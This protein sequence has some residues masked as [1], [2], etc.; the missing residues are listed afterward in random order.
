MKHKI[1]SILLLG[2]ILALIA[3]VPVTPVSALEMEYFPLAPGGSLIYNSTNDDGTWMTKRYIDDEW[4]FLGGPYGTFTILW[5]EAQM[6]PMDTEYTWVNYMWLSKTADTLL[7]WGFE[8]AN[9]KI[10]CSSPL[11]YVTEPV[12]VGAV[13]RGETAG[14]LT[15]KG[16]GTTIPNIAFAANY[17]IEAKETVTTPAGTFENCIKIHEEEITPDGQISFW[18]WYAPDV[19]AIQYYY[20]QNGDRWDVLVE[21]TVDP[22][23]DPWNSWFLPQ[24]PTVLLVTT[25]AVV[26]IIAVV[27]L[28]VIMKKRT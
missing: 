1:L 27:A 7:W 3:S 5:A 9:A 4:E 19:G 21:Y 16:D 15:L 14:T 8:D 24:V 13:H 28:R 6:M 2:A 17:T 25:I 22:E 10:V 12:V 11:S 23:N 18:V 26:A 20:P